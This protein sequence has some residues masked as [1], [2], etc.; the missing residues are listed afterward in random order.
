MMKTIDV[1]TALAKSIKNISA[2][3]DLKLYIITKGQGRKPENK[4]FPN[5][6]KIMCLTKVILECSRFDFFLL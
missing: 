5:H 6:A 1:K 2:S 4:I 3:N